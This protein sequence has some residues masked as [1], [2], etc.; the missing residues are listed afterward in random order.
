MRRPSQPMWQDHLCVALLSLEPLSLEQGHSAGMG[1]AGQGRKFKQA[2]LIKQSKRSEWKAALKMAPVF[3]GGDCLLQP[4]PFSLSLPLSEE[5]HKPPRQKHTIRRRHLP[6][7]GWRIKRQGQGATM[8]AAGCSDCK[9]ALNDTVNLLL[10][11]VGLGVKLLCRWIRLC[12]NIT[13]PWDN[14]YEVDLV[15]GNLSITISQL[16]VHSITAL[17]AWLHVI[18]YWSGR[19]S[20]QVQVSVR[21]RWEG[22]CKYRGGGGR[23]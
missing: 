18:I 15:N 17:P 10:C 16:A 11:F 8:L 1:S 7:Q 19:Q 22:G 9:L 14:C 12:L 5:E 4:P 3:N 6:G 13:C 21:G 2:H 23:Q 20:F